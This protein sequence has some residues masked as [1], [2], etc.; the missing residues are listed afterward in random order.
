MMKLFIGVAGSYG[1]GMFN[2][3]ESPKSLDAPFYSFIYHTFILVLMLTASWSQ[4]SVQV[5]LP[6]PV[7]KTEMKGNSKKA[8]VF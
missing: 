2:F 7:S 4:V 6:T 8:S 5:S 3:K 1:K